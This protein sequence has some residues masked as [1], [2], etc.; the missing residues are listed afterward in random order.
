MR[1]KDRIYM[2]V[3][4]ATCSCL[5]FFNLICNMTTFRKKNPYF[6]RLTSPGVEDVY[7]DRICACMMLNVPFP[8]LLISSMTIFRKQMFWPF[9]PILGLRVCVRTECAPKWCS[10]FHTL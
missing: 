3:H 4:G 10:M 7:K 2:C 9:D 5:I 1:V 6:D 8:F